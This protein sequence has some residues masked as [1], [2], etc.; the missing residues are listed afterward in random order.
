MARA[1]GVEYFH[2]HRLRDTF[3]VE[4]LLGGISVDDVST[5]LGHGGVRTTERYYPPWNLAKRD[6]LAA[7]AREAHR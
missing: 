5:L 7:L 1:V 3:A 4:L 6:R 2:P